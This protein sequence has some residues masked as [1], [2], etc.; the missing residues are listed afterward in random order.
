MQRA[1]YANASLYAPSEWRH[2]L[3]IMSSV[4][5][6]VRLGSGVPLRGRGLAAAAA[7]AAAKLEEEA[8]VA[9]EEGMSS[10]Q[11][12][13]GKWVPPPSKEAG[14][15]RSTLKEISVSS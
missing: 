5:V 15:E 11:T 1:D 10:T 2:A 14:S 6:A 13:A 8:A 12:P 9:S 3:S 4:R 7:A